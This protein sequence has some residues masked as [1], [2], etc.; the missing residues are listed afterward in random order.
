MAI[1]IRIPGTPG[2]PLSVVIERLGDGAYLDFLDAIGTSPT[3]VTVSGSSA[4][5]AVAGGGVATVN[6]GACTFVAPTSTPTAPILQLP[7][8]TSL[9]GISVSG[10]FEV[11]LTSTGLGQW[12]NGDYAVKAMLPSNQVISLAGF[13]MY[14]GDDATPPPGTVSLTSDDEAAIANAIAAALGTSL[15]VASLSPG[16]LSSI[17][18]QILDTEQ[19]GGGPIRKLLRAVASATAGK[20]AQS[21]DGSASQLSDWADQAT[22]RITSVNS[23]TARAVT[24]TP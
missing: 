13:T 12:P 20:I 7:E 24:I 5:V 9:A 15:E 16:A 14:N 21:S 2:A 11:D 10:S 19:A 6:V 18:G 22:T 8:V 17:S 3:T 4:A 23:A 1:R